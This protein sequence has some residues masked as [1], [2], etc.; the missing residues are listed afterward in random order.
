MATIIRR[1]RVLWLQ[2]YDPPGTLNRVSLETRD[3]RQAEIIKRDIENRLAR[4]H[5]VILAGD[6]TVRDV[7][8][9]FLEDKKERREAATYKGYQK[10]WRHLERLFPVDAKIG[11]IQA[12]HIERYLQARKAEGVG[13]VTL[14]GERTLLAVFF[15]W[16]I[17]RD[18]AS[19]N[20]AMKVDAFSVRP[21]PRS[22]V[23]KPE[24]EALCRALI[25]EPVEGAKTKRLTDRQRYVR[26]LLHDAL[27]M[28][29]YSGL[30]L[31]EIADLRKEDVD[32]ED[33]VYYVRSAA[34][35]GP[36]LEP[37]HPEVERILRRRIVLA[38]PYV[39]GT[40]DGEHG[41]NSMHLAFDHFKRA[42]PRFA[43]V[44]FHLLR[45]TFNTRIQEIARNPILAM[46]L[47]GHKTVSMS[48]HY[49]HFELDTLRKVLKK[50][51]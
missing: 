14:N 42:H 11:A 1:G 27:H 34:N 6:R 4:G 51:A 7:F 15:N 26:R 33:L 5:R 35:K 47:T 2:Y 25:D 24:F 17:K 49:T 40:A 30:R 50:L 9:E 13:P 36:R 46:R 16:A 23:S 18:Y 32:L 8:K 12:A 38:G 29:W 31:G 37:M 48:A 21:A 45:H 19:A 22:I 28:A 10:R 44:G 41:R 20:P 3:R 43:N 39:F